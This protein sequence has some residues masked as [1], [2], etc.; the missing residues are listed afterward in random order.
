M[1]FRRREVD[2][3]RLRK[4]AALPDASGAKFWILRVE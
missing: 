1:A 4:A 3:L 2:A